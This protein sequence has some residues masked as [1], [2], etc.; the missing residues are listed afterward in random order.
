[1]F[2]PSLSFISLKL[3]LTLHHIACICYC[4][5]CLLLFQDTQ[6]VTDNDAQSLL[7][8]NSQ[9]EDSNDL[10]VAPN[11][12]LNDDFNNAQYEENVSF[13]LFLFCS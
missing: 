9:H 12:D 6:L 5:D 1:M 2:P 10:N 11:D 4:H 7:V 13:L 3:L 8:K